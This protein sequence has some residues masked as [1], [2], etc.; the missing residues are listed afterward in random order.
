[1]PSIAS[2]FD[3]CGTKNSSWLTKSL[4]AQKKNGYQKS[5]EKSPN[6]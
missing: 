6:N 3:V 2:D 1:M 4:S 5:K